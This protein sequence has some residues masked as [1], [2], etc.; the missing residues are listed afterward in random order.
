MR[1]EVL[2]FLAASHYHDD[3]LHLLSLIA[4]PSIISFK[5]IYATVKSTRGMYAAPHMGVTQASDACVLWAFPN[6]L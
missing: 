6:P 1:R 5:L 4:F 3:F 2:A